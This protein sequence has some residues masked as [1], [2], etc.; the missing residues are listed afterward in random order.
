MGFLTDVAIPSL[1]IVGDMLSKW[2]DSSVQRRNVDKT[3]Q[4]NKDMADLQYQR[5]VDIWNR[6]NEYNSP[7]NQMARF[8]SAGLNPNLIYS[9]G[10]P[11][12]TATALPKYQAPNI[13]YDYKPPVDP[14]SVI[15][16]YQDF[17][18]RQAQ[19]D[20]IRAQADLNK[21]RA[22]TEGRKPGQIDEIVLNYQALRNK[23]GAETANKWFDLEINK[24]YKPKL[25]GTQVTG[26]GYKNLQTL[27]EIR[28]I[29]LGNKLLELTTPYQIRNWALRNIALDKG[30]EVKDKLI[31]KYNYDALNAQWQ[32][33]MRKLGVDTNAPWYVKTGSNLINNI[34]KE[35]NNMLGGNLWQDWLVRRRLGFK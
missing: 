28:K 15:A 5:D 33:E 13:K 3:I 4:A 21:K 11:G 22:E 19:L 18:I 32:Y 6:A 16:K 8:K 20:N 26:M 17:Q 1:P 24:E 14:S 34:K 12:N 10:N 29:G 31:T 25:L 30:N 9:Q 7:Q 2:I 27:Q 35:G 23:Y